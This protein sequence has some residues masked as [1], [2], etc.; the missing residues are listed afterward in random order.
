MFTFEQRCQIPASSEL[1]FNYHARP[2]AFQRLSPPWQRMEIL[3]PTQAMVD[4]AIL[5]MRLLK[6][7]FHCQWH[8][9]HQDVIPGKQFVDVQTQGPFSHWRHTHRFLDKGPDQSELVDHI[10][11]LPPGG[12]LGALLA[13]PKL[14]R[15]LK[16]LFHFRHQRTQQDLLRFSAHPRS[17]TVLFAGQINGWCLQLGYFL[18]CA[19]HKVYRLDHAAGDRY[20]MRSFVTGKVDHPLADCDAL[21][22]TGLPEIP[23][24]AEYSGFEYFDFLQRAL[25]TLANPPHRLIQ[26]VMPLD[27]KPDWQ[28]D[29]QIPTTSAAKVK[30]EEVL[31]EKCDAIAS[32]FPNHTRLFLG[33]VIEPKISQ[34]IK[35][36]LRLETFLFLDNHAK[37]P[38]FHWISRDDLFGSILFLLNQGEIRGDIALIHPTLA[39]R[40][41]LQGLVLKHFF[42]PYTLH[43][44]FQIV[45]WAAPGHG[46]NIH[47]HLGDM[48]TLHSWGFRDLSPSIDQAFLSE[49]GILA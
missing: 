43:R 17:K 33:A 9:L 47:Q 10:E 16:R 6:G 22:L 27:Q 8:A 7:P 34:L 18:S 24:R 14:K 42:F 4:G 36:L 30:L 46:S 28:Q 31:E 5:K 15:E 25:A 11:I 26:F 48:E 1:L 45:G 23:T 3:Q 37:T 20:V 19:G 40:A 38:V 21:I 29:P 41:Q 32:F 35:L 13:G 44:I 2:G 12:R 49:F 39:T